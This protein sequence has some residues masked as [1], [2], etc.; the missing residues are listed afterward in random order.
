MLSG[1]ISNDCVEYFGADE[2][3]KITAGVVS[4]D[5]AWLLD[6][7]H[8]DQPLQSTLDATKH[9]DRDRV[10]SNYQAVM[11]DYRLNAVA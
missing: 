5:V 9:Q 3:A 10:R 7:L 6:R 1:A 4:A 8:K 11:R 2:W